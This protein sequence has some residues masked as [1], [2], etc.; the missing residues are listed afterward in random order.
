MKNKFKVG[1]K[2]LLKNRRGQFWN[3]EGK[4]DKYMG[5]VVTISTIDKTNFEIEE[6][7]H[8]NWFKWRFRFNDI[9]KLVNELTLSDLQFAD[10]LTLR[11][12]ERYVVAD[13][14]MYGENGNCYHDYDKIDWYY[15]ENLTR[16][17]DDTD[18]RE[19]D[20]I[21]VERAGQVIY[22]REEVV[23]MTISEVSEK[24]GYE[25]KIVKENN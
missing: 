22:E 25:V 3:N 17:S 19:Y 20:I 7:D 8:E 1:D 5:K 14:H 9:E 12:G 11:N 13:E 6:D 4:M 16:E 18:D 10:I 15:V 23:E 24:L 2:V 21:K